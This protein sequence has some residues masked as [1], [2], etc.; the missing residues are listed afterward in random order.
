VCPL[1]TFALSFS[2]VSTTNRNATAIDFLA[3]NNII[4][5]YSDGTFQP[6]KSVSRVEFLKLA[7]LSSQVKLDA[8]TPTGFSDIDEN[9]WYAPYLRKA[10]KEG[11]VQ[12]YGDNTFKPTQAVNKVEGL[13]IIAKIQAWTTSQQTE[14]PFKDTPTNEWY[15]PF[16]AYGKYHNFLE[17][18]GN[19]FIPSSSLSR[20][21]TSEILFRALITKG[22][23][24]TTYTP[25]LINKFPADFFINSKIYSPISYFNKSLFLL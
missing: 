10:K 17:E 19:F 13:K 20:A 16:V 1:K 7:L 15:T 3:K 23:G 9:A 4:S 21:K 22:T 14:A 18:T 8:T 11:W 5:G 24:A 6:E 2:D 25:D 12:G